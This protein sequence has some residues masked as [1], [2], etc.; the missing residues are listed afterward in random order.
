MRVSILSS[1]DTLSDIVFTL[2]FNVTFGPP[3]RLLCY[4]N[5]QLTAFFNA[6][7]DSNLIREVIR[8]QYV[9]GSQPDM[10]RVTLKV[11]QPIRENRTYL[12]EVTVEGRVNITSGVYN[13]DPKN[14]TTTTV[15][16]TSERKLHDCIHSAY[17]YY[18]Y[19]LAVA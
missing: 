7:Y 3:S 5:N 4:Y 13:Y 15:T 16:V 10:T 1:R 14:T 8:S 12:C 19:G 6:R 18:Y 9:S 11:V 2:S 17:L